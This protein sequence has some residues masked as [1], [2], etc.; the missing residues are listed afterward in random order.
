MPIL[1]HAAMLLAAQDTLTV[2]LQAATARALAVSPVVAAADAAALGPRGLRAEVW[3]PFPD[4]PA[5]E[6]GRVRRQSGSG[7]VR[8]REWSVTQEIE[9]AGQWAL[10]ASAASGL[11]RSAEARA[12]DARRLVALG[13]RRAYASLAIAERRAGLTDSAAIFGERLA[14]FARRQFETG[15]ANRLELNAAVLE[16]AR[17][18][19][20]A[21]RARAEAEAAAAELARLLAVPPDTAVRATGLPPVPELSWRSDSSLLATARERRADLRAARELL[22]SADRTVAAS[23]LSRVPNVSVS[24]VGGRESGTD[25]LLGLAFG[26]RV[27]LFHRQQAAVGAA[28]AERA[29]AQAEATVTERSIQAEVLTSAARFRRARA[30]ERRFATEVLR[31]ASENVALTERALTEG[32]V[33]VTDVLVLRGAAVAAQ[34][35]YL[36]V[37]RGAA[38]AWF[39]LAAALGAEPEELAVLVGGGR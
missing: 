20:L 27:P 4:N 17:D 3:W 19:S 33:S 36:E 24:A 8:D 18:R 22:R 29:A 39:E 14:T 12:V 26:F 35:E 16:A 30:A 32:E 37:V 1:L 28:Q 2:T 11:V 38:E 15:E 13:V 10:R 21:E 6:Y 7:T 9:I 31:A 34:L 25:N 5:L 23:R